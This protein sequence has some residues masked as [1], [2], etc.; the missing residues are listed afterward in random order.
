MTRLFVI[1]G[2]AIFLLI[3]GC[4]LQ[5]AGQ[6]QYVCADGRTVTDKN[7]CTTAPAG[8]AGGPAA[9]TAGAGATPPETGAP[10][11]GAQQELTL[12]QELGVCAGMPSVQGGSFEDYCII[13]L[14]GKH[15]DPSLCTEV[16]R[17][18]RV[19]CYSLL[20]QLKSSPD[21]C[22][23]AGTQAD[24]C[25]MSYATEKQDA[26]ACGKMKD[27]S[28]KDSCYSQLASRLGEPSLCDKI[29]STNS[30]DN[31]YRDMAQRLGDT[32]YCDKIVT[33]YIKEQCQSAGE[34]YGGPKPVHPA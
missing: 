19:S 7:Q 5:Q 30:K 18:Q 29:K 23:E 14:A 11:A 22:S 33:A 27:I 3:S 34:Q 17:D 4:T 15:S 31:C 21:L 2:L 6:T 16:G 10:A 20:A 28:S 32:T 13:G 1:L 12:D 26:T 9:G 25:Y 8:A 24:Q